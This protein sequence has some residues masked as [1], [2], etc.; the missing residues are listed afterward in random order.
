M[1][2]ASGSEPLVRI[3][4]LRK[5]YSRGRW[6]EK[7]AQLTALDGVDFTLEAGKTLA[8]VGESG[9]G[10]TTLAMCVALL[11]RPDSGRIWFEGC[12]VLSLPRSRAALLRPR[13]Q[14]VFQESATALPPHFS[15][16]E[17]I[18]E[19]LVVQQRYSPKERLELVADLMIKV[20]L[21]P[22][23]QGRFAGLIFQP[24]DG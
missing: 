22:S 1:F 24:R 10:K 16:R 5:T 15:A 7:Q 14:M 6:W 2:S 8:V 13:V 4:G 18:E 12:E 3:A 23:W 17:I 11:D 9:S 21:Q 19:P 20:G